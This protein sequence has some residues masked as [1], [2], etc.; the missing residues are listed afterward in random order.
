[1]RR[2][3][4][5][6]RFKPRPS[7]AQ[8]AC[9]SLQVWLKECRQSL[10]CR[11][12]LVSARQTRI[13]R[14]QLR[15][16]QPELHKEMKVAARAKRGIARKLND[17][18]VSW[19]RK[20]WVGRREAAKGSQASRRRAAEGRSVSGKATEQQG[21]DHERHFPGQVTPSPRKLRKWHRRALRGSTV[22]PSPKLRLNEYRYDQHPLH[23]SR[24][25]DTS[26]REGCYA[27]VREKEKKNGG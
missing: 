4:R 27:Q 5:K 7:R 12:T 25:V 20:L 24:R 15:E 19:A 9:R 22:T 6:R 18:R 2:L 3:K 16:R 10:A 13:V 11:P 21:C 1:M 26:P 23:Q 17:A 8:R 14:Q